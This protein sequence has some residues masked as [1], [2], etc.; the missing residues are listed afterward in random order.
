MKKITVR[1]ISLLLVAIMLTVSGIG[2]LEVKAEEEFLGQE[3]IENGMPEEVVPEDLDPE[4]SKDPENSEP[5]KPEEPVI[6]QEQ[7]IEI[8]EIE[9]ELTLYVND[10]FQMEIIQTGDGELTYESSTPE[11]L[12]VD[13]TGFLKAIKDGEA[14]L[15]IRAAETETYQAAEIIVP[16]KVVKKDQEIKGKDLE[17]AFG[18]AAKPVVFDNPLNSVPTFT[19][20]DP[21]IATVDEEGNVTPLKT[22]KTV[23]TIFVPGNEAFND[24][25]INVNIV[26]KT[27]LA[28][29][30]LLKATGSSGKIVI[31]W[32]KV[33]GAD[34]YYLYEKS[35]SKYVL[36]TTI[37]NPNTLTY[38]RSNV[39]SG[40][41]YS[42]YV[43]AFATDKKNIS[44]KSNV[45]SGKYLLAPSLEVKAKQAAVNLKWSEVTGAEGYYLYRRTSTSGSWTNIAKITSGTTVTWKDKGTVNAKTNYY[46]VKA[47]Y[48]DSIGDLS[49]SKNAYYLKS[50][51][52]KSA[53]KKSKSTKMTVKWSRNKSASGY[54]IQ[55][56]DNRFF[57]KSKT[58]TIKKNSTVSKKISKLSK[59]KKYYVRV[60][61]YKTVSGKKIY[62]D[63]SLSSNVKTTKSISTTILKYKKKTFELKGKA[64]QKL[65]G[66]DTVQGGCSDG[67]YGYYVLYNR[68][69]E[70]CKIVKVKLSNMK[71][72]K[73]SGIL[74][75]AH[76]NDL[77]YNSHTKRLVV[78]HTNV[79]A[80]RISIIN[81][82]S[83]K[84]EKSYDVKIPTKMSGVSDKELKKANGFCGIAYNA[85]KKQYA[86][87]MKNTG[88]VMILN[89]SFVPVSYVKLSTKSS[90]T[91]Q[92]IDATDDYILISYSGSTN[93]IMVYTWD[94][95][96]VSK[97]NVKK[98]YEIENVYHVGKQYY[99]SFY[100]SKYKNGKLLKRD[101]YVYKLKGL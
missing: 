18:E 60:R 14:E 92:G 35:G 65:G 72:E 43:I 97:I 98:G 26:V 64:K 34:G 27:T 93:I 52:I 39:S 56:A 40:K 51:S 31:G 7:L 3:E 73:V 42:Y 84:V 13:E 71:V 10:E 30:E 55:Y 57:Y 81:P 1:L 25:E 69:V 89:S 94:G 54:Q 78:T 90:L 53:T 100:A 67:K 17:F 48:S 50:P 95:Q 74:Y 91:K 70:N 12:E 20:K 15:I 24:A 59:S 33:T 16:V 29:P 6:K 21:D 4:N 75:I 9:Q 88:D 86:A 47:Y 68:K 96:Y 8:K 66:Y 41:Q 36:L 5:E 87:L 80:K 83:L 77:T 22:G 61:A 32:K 38:T 37:N 101:N 19:I 85:K 76:G 23:L 28:K 82:S 58:V 44:D 99:A 62:S 2:E 46:C 63:W 45:K 11:V 49:S 79:N